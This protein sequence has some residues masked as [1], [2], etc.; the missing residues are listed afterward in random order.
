MW[1]VSTG[2]PPDNAVFDR[3]QFGERFFLAFFCGQNVIDIVLGNAVTQQCPFHVVDRA[4]F[5]GTFA[6]IFRQIEHVTDFAR[7]FDTGGHFVGAIAERCRIHDLRD[8]AVAYQKIAKVVFGRG[9]IGPDSKVF[10]RIDF[11]RQTFVTQADGIGCHDINQIPGDVSRFVHGAQLGY[12]LGRT[13]VPGDGHA[14]I[15]RNVRFDIRLLLAGL[16]RTAPRHKRKFLAHAVAPGIGHA[17]RG[18]RD[19][20]NQSFGQFHTG[21]P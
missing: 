14:A 6:R 17:S 3:A 4:L 10:F 12:G 16:I 18:N 20:G 13:F 9:T 2:R 19:T 7:R 15:G 8:K 11:Q 1:R 21:L 5:Q